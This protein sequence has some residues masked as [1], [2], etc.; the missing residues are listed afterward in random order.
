MWWRSVVASLVVGGLLF[1]I[2][3]D[4]ATLLSPWTP[5]IW[6]R[7]ALSMTVPFVVSLTSAVLTRRELLA[8]R[9]SPRESA[10][11]GAQR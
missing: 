1:L 6:K 4:I 11:I 10:D 3:H 8:A 7:L 5:S 2:N 9:E